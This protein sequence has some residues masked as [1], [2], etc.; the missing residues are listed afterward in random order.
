MS[1]VYDNEEYLSM[2]ELYRSF[3]ADKPAFSKFLD[4]TIVSPDFDHPH[5]IVNMRSDLAGNAN[6]NSL[7][8]GVIASILDIIG[9]HAVFMSVF[10][11]MRG[12][13]AE[14]KFKRVSKIGSIDLRVDYLSPGTGTSFSAS[15]SILRIGNKVAVVRMELHNNKDILIA[16][17]T[18]SYTVG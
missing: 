6:H 7:H 2:I 15:A 9:G 13:S 8:T 16:L 14:N 17:G 4:F 12:Q 3:S 1:T 11:Q 10:K 5:L 18:G